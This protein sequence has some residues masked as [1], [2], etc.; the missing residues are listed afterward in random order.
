MNGAT[1]PNQLAGKHML[2]ISELDHCPCVWDGGGLVDVHI[3]LDGDHHT[4]RVPED[5]IVQFARDILRS[6]ESR[7]HR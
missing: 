3:E 2:L 1:L 4:I 6:R 7:Q 5:Q